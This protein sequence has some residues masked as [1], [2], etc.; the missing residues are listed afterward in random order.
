MLEA[1]VDGFKA[2]S[3]H[4]FDIVVT[5]INQGYNSPEAKA[6]HEKTKDLMNPYLIGDKHSN[7]NGVANILG[8]LIGEI[9]FCPSSGSAYFYYS[10]KKFIGEV[11]ADVREFL[12]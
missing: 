9:L 5:N 3:V 12:K 1:F 7:L 10:G 2:G 4:Q 11:V 8:I 6:L